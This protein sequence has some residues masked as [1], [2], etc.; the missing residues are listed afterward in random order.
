MTDGL[1]P[2]EI[3]TAMNI[4]IECDDGVQLEVI[5]RQHKTTDNKTGRQFKTSAHIE[6]DPKKKAAIEKAVKEAYKKK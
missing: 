6:L 3:V 5:A 2:H 1:K 4:V